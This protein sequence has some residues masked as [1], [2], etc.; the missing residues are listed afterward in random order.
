[1]KARIPLFALVLAL[2]ALIANPGPAVAERDR[3]SREE[4]PSYA[5]YSTADTR[6]SLEQAIQSVQRATG[7]RVLDAREVRDGYRIK[8]LTRR[9]EVRVVYVDAKTGAMR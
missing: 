7:G 5:P 2:T 3:W 9:G 1:M 6:V 8:V 4:A